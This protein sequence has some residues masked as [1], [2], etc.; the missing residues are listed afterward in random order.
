MLL[1]VATL[2]GHLSMRALVVGGVLDFEGLEPPCRR[3]SPG[4]VSSG[5]AGAGGPEPPSGE[6]LQAWAR[7]FCFWGFH[8]DS[9]R[10]ANPPSPLASQPPIWPLAIEVAWRPTQGIAWRS[11]A[12]RWHIIVETVRGD[13]LP[14]EHAAR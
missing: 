13:P 14:W 10:N 4:G 2:G 9:D 8:G 12:N 7:C 11:W 5:G 6:P 1:R 3:W